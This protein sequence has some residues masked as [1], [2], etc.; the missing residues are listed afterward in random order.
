MPQR[1][2]LN[3][4]FVNTLNRR[5]CNSLGGCYANLGKKRSG[6]PLNRPSLPDA[7]LAGRDDRI[8]LVTIAVAHQFPHQIVRRNELGTIV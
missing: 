1:A 8:D 5:F 6:I 7:K 4:Q 3:R 2:V